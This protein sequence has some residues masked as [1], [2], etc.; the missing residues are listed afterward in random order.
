MKKI[1][2]A[3]PTYNR[4]KLLSKLVESIPSNIEISISDNGKYLDQNFVKKHNNASIIQHENLLDIFYN[5]NSAIKNIKHCDYVAIP[6]DDD[7]YIFNTFDVIKNTINNDDADVFIF[8]NNFINENDEIKGSYCPKE[9][10]VCEAPYGLYEFLYGVNVRM[11]SV[12]FKKSFLDRIGY[13]DEKKFTLTAADSELI[14]RALLLGKVIFIPK[15]VS[16]YRVWSG[17]LTDQKIATKH[18]MDEIDIW[19]DKIINLAKIN[20]SES[21]NIFDWNK[22][23]DEIYA[24]NLSGGLS[25]LYRSKQYKKV[26]E[27]YSNMRYPKHAFFKTK[28]RIMKII[29]VSMVKNFYAN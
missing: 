26:F 17:G 12:F 7:M 15:I 10:K 24:R 19:T 14:Q 11:P 2:I 18:W 1:T 6:S 22:Y 13:F 28:L 3:I 4:E 5:W 27:H 25:N 21:Q 20:L 9:Y 29:L 8:G 16:S 23:K